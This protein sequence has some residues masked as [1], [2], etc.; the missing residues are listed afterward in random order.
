M[1]KG[2]DGIV[3]WIAWRW[4]T[5][6]GETKDLTGQRRALLGQAGVLC[7]TRGYVEV[8][9]RAHNQPGPIV[10]AS[11]RDMIQQNLRLTK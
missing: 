3:E 5:I 9:V 4:L 8:S 11:A 7:V 6:Q 2:I 10:I 1:S